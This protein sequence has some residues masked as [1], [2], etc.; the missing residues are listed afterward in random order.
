MSQCC[1]KGDICIVDEMLAFYRR[2]ALAKYHSAPDASAVEQ[3]FAEYTQRCLELEDELFL[4]LVSGLTEMSDVAKVM[5][6]ACRL[7]KKEWA[8][9][10]ATVECSKFFNGL[11]IPRLEEMVKKERER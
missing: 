6:T 8:K 1:R 2:V 3:K 10:L 7:D 5:T 4:H 9:V 11:A